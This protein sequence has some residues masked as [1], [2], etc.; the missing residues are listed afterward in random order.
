M[1]R[2]VPFLD[3]TVGKKAVMAVTGL[4]LFGFVVVHMIGNLQAYIGP[5]SLNAYGLWLRELLHGT[6]LWIARGVLILAVILHVWAAVGLT[7]ENRKARPVGYRQRRWEESTYASRTMVWSGPILALFIVYHLLH[8]T[9]GNVHPNFVDGDVYHNFVSGFR[10]VPVSAFYILAMLGLGLHLYHGVW[11]MLQT[12]GLSHPRWNPLR[13][14]FAGTITT[15]VVLGNV[16]F[17]IAVLL[18]IIR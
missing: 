10:V 5:E 9:T 11:S 7:I 3:A 2:A 15:V 17:P 6:G 4:V 16:S 14:A 12:L 13:A 8:L 1:P 18:G